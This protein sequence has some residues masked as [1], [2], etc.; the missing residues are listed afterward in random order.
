METP[1]LAQLMG[2]Y[3]HQDWYEEHHDEWA[4]LDDFLEGESLAPRLPDEVEHVLATFDDDEEIGEYLWSIGSYYVPDPAAGGYRGW[5][6]E[7]AK[8]ARERLG[9]R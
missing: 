3:F 5:L 9:Q 6:T 7:I 4:N 1:A 2:A 8:R